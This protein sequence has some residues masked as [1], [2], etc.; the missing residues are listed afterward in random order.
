MSERILELRAR[1][2]S[3]AELSYDQAVEIDD[4]K[5]PLWR[6]I[7]EFNIIRIGEL[8][9]DRI[10][11]DTEVSFRNLFNGKDKEEYA[12]D[13]SDYLLQRL[14]GKPDYTKA[15]GFIA[16]PARHAHLK[17]DAASAWYMKDL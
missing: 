13:F 3:L 16:L 17:L 11:S 6:K 15:K 4:S 5:N 8:F 7:G 1:A 2:L 10:Y 12:G 9:S 14:G